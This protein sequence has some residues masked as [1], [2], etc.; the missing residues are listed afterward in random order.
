MTQLDL[1][2]LPGYRAARRVNGDR[3]T[4]SNWLEWYAT[5]E[6]A[7]AFSKLFWPDFVEWRGCILLADAFS[8]QN[9]EEWWRTF[10]G[11]VQ[12]VEDMINHTHLC[13]LFPN[14][15]GFH[16]IDKGVTDYL[17]TTLVAMWTARLHQLFP[18]RDFDVI[19]DDYE[20]GSEPIVV[21]TQRVA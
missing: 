7:A 16:T 15:H 14:D 6:L 21:V 18:D 10:H 13:D 11:D 2:L 17:G 4:L 1:T 8:E 19:F 12:R 20:D 5:I 9:A 3:F